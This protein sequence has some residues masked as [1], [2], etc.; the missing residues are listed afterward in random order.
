MSA[1]QQS[2]PAA[3]VP[4]YLAARV[5]RSS[6]AWFP[7]AR[8]AGYA[9]PSVDVRAETKRGTKRK[10]AQDGEAE[11]EQEEGS[12]VRDFVMAGLN[13]E[14]FKELLEGFHGLGRHAGAVAQVAEDGRIWLTV[15]QQLIG[16]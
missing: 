3:P 4:K 11:D 1:R 8:R 9:L 10:R 16:R 13:E 12:A 15:I 6:A 7:F 2:A 5:A 14:L